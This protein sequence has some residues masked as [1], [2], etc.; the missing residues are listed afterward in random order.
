MNQQEKLFY[1]SI[2]IN[3]VKSQYGEVFLELRKIIELHDPMQL[4]QYETEGEY[5]PE[6]ASILI[7]LQNNFVLQEVH[8]LVYNDFSFWFEDIVGQKE[9]YK[10]LSDAIYAWI[11]NTEIIK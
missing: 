8:D 6:T 4:N 10:E 7:Q 2:D 11:K 1:K 9:N 5:D 3:L